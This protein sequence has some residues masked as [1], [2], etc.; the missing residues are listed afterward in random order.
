MDLGCCGRFGSR[1][2][3]SFSKCAAF[4]VLFRHHPSDSS[5]WGQD[6]LWTVAAR[7]EPLSPMGLYRGGP[8]GLFEPTVPS[9]VACH[10]T[11]P[12]Y[13]R[14]QGACKSGGSGGTAFGRSH[15]SRVEH[16]A[17]L[18]GSGVEA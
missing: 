17:T 6:A 1:R 10:P 2:N 12:A 14:T 11:L 16:G 3:P 8:F 18:S 7:C 9:R 13:S 4:G 15:L 5:E